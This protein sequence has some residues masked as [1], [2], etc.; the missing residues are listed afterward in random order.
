MLFSL[1]FCA[2]AHKRRTSTDQQP[3]SGV[4]YLFTRFSP[5]IEHLYRERGYRETAA[6]DRIQHKVGPSP[7]VP[8]TLARL[9]RRSCRL[10][11]G[12]FRAVSCTSTYMLRGA[13]WE[14][15]APLHAK[16]RTDT[17]PF[18]GNRRLAP[19]RTLSNLS[20]EVCYV[21]AHFLKLKNA[22]TL[23]MAVFATT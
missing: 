2:V 5:Q 23:G 9:P 20:I 3:G 15:L 17:S 18:A 13:N 21:G 6:G 14:H 7:L 19:I 16:N 11:H 12:P 8:H 4:A 10:P 1:L 22:R